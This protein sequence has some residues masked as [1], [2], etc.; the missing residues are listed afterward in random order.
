MDFGTPLRTFFKKLTGLPWDPD[1]QLR[2]QK[3]SAKAKIRIWVMR[4][5]MKTKNVI[6]WEV[7]G[8]NLYRGLENAKNVYG[9]H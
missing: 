4:F 3:I 8:K 1:I 6:C 9:V 2:L 5:L 7:D